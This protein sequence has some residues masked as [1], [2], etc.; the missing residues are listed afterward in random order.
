MAK[1][2]S[3]A[4]DGCFPNFFFAF[5]KSI[6]GWTKESVPATDSWMHS[7]GHA[8]QSKT[9]TDVAT[10][11][12]LDICKVLSGFFRSNKARFLAMRSTSEE[13][14]SAWLAFVKGNGALVRGTW[15][16]QVVGR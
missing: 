8:G 7:T 1:L 15:R 13:A 9:E 10:R 6:G 14:S 3:D 12:C 11:V 5:C 16:A 4:K 2:V